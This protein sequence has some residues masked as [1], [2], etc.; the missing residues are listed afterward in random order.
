MENLQPLEL[1]LYFSSISTRTIVVLS[2]M[3]QCMNAN[4]FDQNW[5]RKQMTTACHIGIHYLNLM[6]FADFNLIN[7]LTSYT[8]ASKKTIFPLS[9]LFVE[10]SR[11]IY[12]F[13]KRQYKNIRK[14]NVFRKNITISAKESSFEP[15][16]KEISEGNLEVL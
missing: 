7:Q 15:F 1:T 5:T 10:L 3:P 12:Y 13:K 9:K 8:K 14:Q 4:G 2:G 16:I 11:T 6:K